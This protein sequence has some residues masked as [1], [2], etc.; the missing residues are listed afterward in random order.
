MHF[1]REIWKAS[2]FIVSQKGIEVDP[3]KVHAILEM[4]HPCTEKEIRG[5]LGRLKLYC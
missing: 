5:F 3:D 4:P 1:W 2:R